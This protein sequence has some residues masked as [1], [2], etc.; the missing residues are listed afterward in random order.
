M[1]QNAELGVRMRVSIG[2]R[3]RKNIRIPV[4][5]L[6]EGMVLAKDLLTTKGILLMKAGTRFSA[7]QTQRVISM[8]GE[9]DVVEVADAAA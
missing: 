9:A 2:V 1:L 7:T 3:S 6:R 4:T 5:K 8:L